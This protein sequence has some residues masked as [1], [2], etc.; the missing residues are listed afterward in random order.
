MSMIA[1]ATRTE[2]RGHVS[3]SQMRSVSEG[4]IKINANCVTNLPFI[5]ICNKDSDVYMNANTQSNLQKI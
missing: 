5:I 1:L 3:C 4:N 2:I